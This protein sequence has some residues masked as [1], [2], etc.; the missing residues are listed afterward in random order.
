MRRWLISVLVTGTALAFAAPGIAS[1]QI[2]WNPMNFEN[3]LQTTTVDLGGEAVVAGSI[4]INDSACTGMLWNIAMQEFVGSGRTLLNTTT[5]S[6][7][8]PAGTTNYPVSFKVAPGPSRTLV[9]TSQTFSPCA[10]PI[11]SPYESQ[12]ATLVRPTLAVD[13]PLVRNKQSVLFSG[14]VPGSLDFGRP[15]VAMQARTGK[16]WRTFKAVPVNGSGNF[17]A[18]YRFTQTGRRQLYKFRAK[19]I[20]DPGSFPYATR[21]STKAKVLVL[22]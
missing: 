6:V 5:Y 10:L 11:V 13:R 21:A 19:V 9:F 14:V 15:A 2:V 22:P 20:A 1:A 17:S 16:K 4:T 3:G 7:H 18:R 12:I 8:V